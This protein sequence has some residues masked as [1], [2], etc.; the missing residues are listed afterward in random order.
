[1]NL[2]QSRYSKNLVVDI[3]KPTV[4][5]RKEENF[6][7]NFVIYLI[8]LLCM[9]TWKW[10]NHFL[11][12]RWLKFSVCTLKLFSKSIIKMLSNEIF[13]SVFMPWFCVKCFVICANRNVFITVFPCVFFNPH[14]YQ[15]IISMLCSFIYLKG[16]F[17]LSHLNW[18]CFC[19]RDS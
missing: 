11:L 15:W 14:L 13:C 10:L 6:M 16:K 19:N 9:V 4:N 5:E 8:F 1:M 12:L 17:G 18:F 3:K 7:S 2:T